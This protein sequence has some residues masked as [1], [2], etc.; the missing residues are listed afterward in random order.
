MR[1]EQVSLPK[2]SD[3]L[4]KFCEKV[5]LALILGTCFQSGL[6]ELSLDQARGVEKQLECMLRLQYETQAGIRLPSEKIGN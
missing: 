5:V 3:R 1:R 4:F 6:K 2:V